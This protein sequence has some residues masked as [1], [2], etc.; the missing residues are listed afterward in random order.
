MHEV[1]ILRQIVLRVS[2]DHPL[3]SRA[4]RTTLI[5]F[6]IYVAFDHLH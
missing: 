4:S 1:V 2:D 5:A 6:P 3:E